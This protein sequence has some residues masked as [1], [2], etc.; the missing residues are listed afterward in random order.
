MVLVIEI[1]ILYFRLAMS[2]LQ[3]IS[4]YIF[5]PQRFR[6]LQ[7][8]CMFVGY[9]RSGHSLVGS[10]LDAHPNCIISHELDA[11]G[12]LNEMRSRKQLFEQ[13]ELNSAKYA[14]EGRKWTG[15]TYDIEGQWQGR[16]KEIK[17]IG[18]KKGGSSTDH[19][20][21][22]SQV[23]DRL[24]EFVKLPILIIHVIRNPFDVISTRFLKGENP[25]Q[26]KGEELLNE[27]ILSHIR[28]TEAIGRLR[29]TRE[30]FDL[31]SEDLKSDPRLT[32]NHLLKFLN[33]DVLDDFLDASVSIID[34]KESRTRKKV[35]WLDYQVSKI[36]DLICQHDFLEGYTFK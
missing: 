8:Y 30:M 3:K 18:D 22:D 16:L 15:Y 25:P 34:T 11:L 1:A 33:L 19:F 35:N 10:I 6:G 2:I 29:N 21:A 36:E 14:R 17:I 24:E 31:R 27:I 7:Y 23:I 13:I 4:D 28:M 26:L 5:M 12:I 9:P 20:D 32:L